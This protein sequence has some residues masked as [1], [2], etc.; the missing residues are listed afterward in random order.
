MVTVQ[1]KE[2]IKELGMFE[3]QVAEVTPETFTAHKKQLKKIDFDKDGFGKR[4]ENVSV[5]ETN[6]DDLSGQPSEPKPRGT[7]R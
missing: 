5:G 6:A 3:G 4:N 2:L 7:K 1:A